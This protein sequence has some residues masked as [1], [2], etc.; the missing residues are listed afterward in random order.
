MA[1]DNPH[2]SD[3]RSMT[4]YGQRDDDCL[5]EGAG[6]GRVIMVTNLLSDITLDLDTP[7]HHQHGSCDDQTGDVSL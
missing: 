1:C 5:C 6:D 2:V 4:A 7:W 3:W